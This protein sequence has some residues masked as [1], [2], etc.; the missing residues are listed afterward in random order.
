MTEIKTNDMLSNHSH[1]LRFKSQKLPMPKILIQGFNMHCA[2]LQLKNR[3]RNEGNTSH[4]EYRNR[5][6]PFYTIGFHSSISC[7]TLTV[8]CFP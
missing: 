3:L 6:K 1:N 4:Q 2:Q 5:L 8:V 7:L